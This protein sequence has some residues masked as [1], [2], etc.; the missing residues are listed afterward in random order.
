MLDE[1]ARRNRFRV[2]ALCVL[3]ILALALGYLILEN[4]VLAPRRQAADLATVAQIVEQAQRNDDSPAPPTDNSIAVL[5]FV[6]MS[7]GKDQEYMSDGIS[8][9][10]LN[11]LAKIPQLRV[12]ARTSSFSFKGKELDVATIANKIAGRPRAGRLGAKV[13]RSHP[14]H[15]AVGSR[16]RQFASVVGNLRSHAR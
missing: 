16:V 1:P 10:L 9:E 12:I 11:L 13:R 15:R 3:G 2:A 5:P 4:L 6:D 7:P 8:E 14:H